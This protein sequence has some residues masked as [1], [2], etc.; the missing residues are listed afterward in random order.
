MKIA[1]VTVLRVIKVIVISAQKNF[2]VEGDGAALAINIK[3]MTG[4]DGKWSIISTDGLDA[5]E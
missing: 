5:D 1:V 3:K 4:A 2:A